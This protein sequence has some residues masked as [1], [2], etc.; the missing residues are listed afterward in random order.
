MSSA[1][2]VQEHSIMPAQTQPMAHPTMSDTATVETAE[3]QFVRAKQEAYLAE[4]DKWR[5]K[6][7]Y[8]ISLAVPFAD[9]L[10]K[11]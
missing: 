11:V 1:D 2:S 7:M 6:C 9:L 10:S 4:G 3:V 8:L 5:A